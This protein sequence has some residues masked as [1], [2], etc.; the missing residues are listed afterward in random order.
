M[1]AGGR[2]GG[3]P[4]RRATGR[5]GQAGDPPSGTRRRG[6]GREGRRLE[7]PEAGPAWAV[8]GISGAARRGEPL[9]PLSR[10]PAAPNT[11][12]CCS[13]SAS[14]WSPDSVWYCLQSSLFVAA[15][16][17]AACG[18]RSSSWVRCPGTRKLEF[19]RHLWA[20]LLS[21]MG[22]Q[23]PS[24]PRGDVGEVLVPEC[25]PSAVCL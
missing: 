11:A 5:G 23:P 3:R 9:P 24:R 25:A 2:E 18:A 4:P 10:T 7:G 8:P 1:A 6:P 19:S 15:G 21:L 20:E 16:R 14:S 13:L 12:R 17:L 22:P